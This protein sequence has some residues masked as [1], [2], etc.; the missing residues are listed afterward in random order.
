LAGQRIV[1]LSPDNPSVEV[2]RYYSPRA[3]GPTQKFFMLA[4][5]H[6]V[7]VVST[8]DGTS[9]NSAKIFLFPDESSVEGMERW[10]NSQHSDALFPDAAEPISSIDIP[11]RSFRAQ[12]SPPIEHEVGPGGDEYD[13]VRVD[14]SVDA[15]ETEGVKVLPSKASLKA[16]IRTKDLPPR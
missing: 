3:H 16:F 10:G 11:G 5:E 13:R 6:A 9:I 14:F 2:S 1:S 7:V 15:F 8:G 4:A 12:A